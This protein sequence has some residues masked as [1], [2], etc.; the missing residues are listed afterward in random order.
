[1]SPLHYSITAIALLL[2]CRVTAQGLTYTNFIRQTQY[3]SKVQW[4][5]SLASAGSQLAAL[6]IEQGGA[7]FELWTVASGTQL[8]SYLLSSGYVGAYIPLA[9][10]ALRSEDNTSTLPRTRADRPF[11]VDY[12]VSGLQTGMTY[13]AASMSVNLLRYVQAYPT[14]GTNVG[15]DR[16]Q[17]TLLTQS[18]TTTNGSQTLT[19][20]L[21][22]IPNANRSKV[23]GEERFSVYSIAD[24][25]APSA[26]LASQFIQIWPVADGSITGIT[27][28]QLIRYSLPQLT[29]TLNDLYPTS[30]TY[31]QVYKGEAALGTTGSIVPGSALVI[32]DS[33]PHCS[34]L[35]LKDYQAVF[36]SE[37]RW[38]ME[39]LTATPFGIDRLAYVS[40][41]IDRTIK[42]NGTLTT[43]E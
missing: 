36:S 22:S 2:S 32:N 27:M 8:T 15:I 18:S 30:S 4:D 17:A 16:T 21:T 24:Y 26:I 38:T 23:R 28:N 6:A 42:V 11:F 40:F 19:F 41:N 12:T 14:G 33:V 25:Q 29:L 37:G 1:M 13:P 20:A 5:T 43:A 35:T 34:V 31:A 7:N 10:V 39:L 9:T 3:P